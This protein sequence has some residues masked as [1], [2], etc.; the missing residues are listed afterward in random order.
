[1]YRLDW[2]D[3]SVPVMEGFEGQ[4][5]TLNFIYQMLENPWWVRNGGG[6]WRRQVVGGGWRVKGGVLLSYTTD[7]ES[8]SSLSQE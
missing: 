3:R 2:W 8:L 5:V 1:M 6:I 4:A 7:T